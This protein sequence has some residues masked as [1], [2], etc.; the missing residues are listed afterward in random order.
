MTGRGE[1]FRLNQLRFEAIALNLAES[2]VP[3]VFAPVMMTSAI[4]PAISPYSIAVA[5]VSSA[6][7]REKRFFTSELRM[8]GSKARLGYSN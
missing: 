6:M 4:R 7:K 5:A 8:T 3:S 2:F 1:A